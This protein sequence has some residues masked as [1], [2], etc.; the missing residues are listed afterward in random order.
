M[1]N[2]TLLLFIMLKWNK[3][4]VVKYLIQEHFIG[5]GEAQHSNR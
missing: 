3:L 5:N 1:I 2:E 4:R